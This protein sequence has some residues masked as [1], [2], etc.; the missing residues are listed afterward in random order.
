[1]RKLLFDFNYKRGVG[2]ALA[3]YISWILI[4]LVVV[5]LLSF[6]FSFTGLVGESLIGE[7]GT[8]V[9]AFGA[10]GLSIAVLRA[11]KHKGILYMTLAG[12]AFLVGIMQGAIIAFIIPA[13]FTMLKPKP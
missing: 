7:V 10:S 4:S 8:L 5:L 9:A 1:M 3:F 2:T 11:K 12:V 6:V 13:F